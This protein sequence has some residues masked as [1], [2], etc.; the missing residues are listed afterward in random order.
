MEKISPIKDKILLFIEKE[1]ITK[2]DFCEKT[3]ISYANMKGKG[4][5]SE[6]GG[7]QI[8]K[9]LSTYPKISP[10][11]LLTGKGP[12]LKDNDESKDYHQQADILS[13]ESKPEISIYKLKTDYYGVGRQ[14]IPLYEI[15]ATAGLNTLFSSDSA[16]VPIDHISVPNAP[17][18]DGALFV[19]GDSMH[20]LLKAGDIICY[21][22]INSIDNIIFGEIYILDLDDG[23]D[24]LLVVKYVQKSDKGNK[25]IKL[26]SENKYYADK[27]EPI[28]NIRALGIIKLTIR[29][30]TIS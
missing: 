25:Y 17:K 13:Q 28:K 21:K 23:D 2:V 22:T 3:G 4:L 1:G 20:P 18:C 26:V 16:Q 12:M 24:Q 30:N 14:S 29:Y 10:E 5:H 7:T 27:D 6:I 15:E 9:I 8:G 11:W 19:R